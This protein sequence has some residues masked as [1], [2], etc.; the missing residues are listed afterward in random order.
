MLSSPASGPRSSPPSPSH[1][2]Y[3]LDL[4]ALNLDDDETGPLTPL[5]QPTIDVIAS[6][7]I[8]GPT[9]FTVNMGKWMR[10][11]PRKPAAV[12]DW[13]FE[14]TKE[15]A[16]SDEPNDMGAVA[17]ASSEEAGTSPA[18]NG[19]PADNASQQVDKAHESD[20][21]DPLR[22]EDAGELV[23]DDD[24]DNND[25]EVNAY[26]AMDGYTDEGSAT[27]RQEEESSIW[28]PYHNSSSLRLSRPRRLLQPTVEDYNSELTPARHV[29]ATQRILHATPDHPRRTGPTSG[30]PYPSSP[31][32][33]SSPTLSPVVTK[34]KENLSAMGNAELHQLREALDDIRTTEAEAQKEMASLRKQLEQERR[35]T[36]AHHHELESRKAG[37]QKTEQAEE[38]PAQGAQMRLEEL[39]RDLDSA[40]RGE[41]K[42]LQL[43]EQNR[44]DLEAARNAERDAAELAEKR[45]KELDQMHESEDA[46]LEDL[47]WQLH[48]TQDS[49]RNARE[50]L[51]Q[52]KAQMEEQG[53]AHDEEVQ[54]LGRNL[55]DTKE[56]AHQ[57]REAE[58]TAQE[59]L[60]VLRQ[61]MSDHATALRD[62][63]QRLREELN[64][65]QGQEENARSEADRYYAEAQDLKAARNQGQEAEKTTDH[66]ESM[67]KAEEL[68]QG[69][70]R[71]LREAQAQL[72]AMLRER[73]ADHAAREKAEEEA[74]G[75]RE[76]IDMLQNLSKL[77]DVDEGTGRDLLKLRGE[78]EKTL[79]LVASLR[80][81]ME[82]LQQQQTMH[83]AALEQARSKVAADSE[84]HLKLLVEQKE[85]H[86]RTIDLIEEGMASLRHDRESLSSQVP[87]LKQDLEHA[88]EELEAIR[89]VNRAFD[90]RIADALRKREEGWRVKLREAKLKIRSLE[91]KV[92]HLEEDRQVMAKAL[93]NQWGREE[94]G[95][96][97]KKAAQRYAYQFA[98]K[99]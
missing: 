86:R 76:E 5:P 3:S 55:A 21:Q 83:E 13:T 96:E 24:N 25:D 50:S 65:A 75:L 47:R 94:C 46:E 6:D 51:G 15:K 71:Q 27:P 10:G 66:D 79:E 41:E 78:H 70:E 39:M 73:N 90:M 87:I 34:K 52:L 44:K 12:R 38:G 64:E 67:A 16:D 22:V 8:D 29:S 81:E 30:I 11:T 26:G 53:R 48:Q 85:E 98:S 19:G 17:G 63:T 49:E 18:E 56:E 54:C 9:D 37:Q 40:R 69:L 91:E 33:P 42:A 84:G 72:N 1:S 32:R 45:A 20:P 97:D 58:Q 23:D 2:H 35:A 31:A 60:R 61:Q 28:E 89:E 36:T 88:R 92:G 4:D 57:A 43:A 59:N 68:R 80:S 95:I 62:E 14:Q 99:V 93:L 7:D 74:K 77:D 82:A